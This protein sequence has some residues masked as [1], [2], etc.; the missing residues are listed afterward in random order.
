MDFRCETSLDDIVVEKRHELRRNH[1]RIVG[2]EITTNSNHPA[3][4]TYEDLQ[5]SSRLSPN[6][7]SKIQPECI[8]LN[9]LANNLYVPSSPPPIIPPKLNVKYI[10]TSKSNSSSLSPNITDAEN[11]TIPLVNSLK[12]DSSPDSAK[13]T[14]VQEGSWYDIYEFS[15]FSIIPDIRII[16]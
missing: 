10:D 4:I 9:P 7:S 13:F 1:Q 11:N 14:V 2:S 12:L 15:Y 5:I 6:I 16:F 8:Y 3:K